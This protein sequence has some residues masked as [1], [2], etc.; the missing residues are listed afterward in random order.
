MLFFFFCSLCVLI[1]FKLKR[2][3][4]LIP[5]MKIKQSYDVFVMDYTKYVIFMALVNMKKF[6]S[7]FFFFCSFSPVLDLL[8][9]V[10]LPACR[11]SFSI[12][13]TLSPVFLLLPRFILPALLRSSHHS[14]SVYFPL[15][16]SCISII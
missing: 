7:F 15:C 6:L 9:D 8:Q 11:P 2:S 12:Q 5:Y 10:G 3:R 1:N 4:T 13:D 14:F 16:N